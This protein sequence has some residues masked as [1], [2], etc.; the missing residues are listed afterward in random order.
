METYIQELIS[1]QEIPTRD[2][3]LGLYVIAK[4]DAEINQVE[5]AIVA[6]GRQ[7]DL[8]V[9]S[10]EA[11]LSLTELMND[12]DVSHQDA[13]DV[14]WP[15]S[16]RLDSFVDLMARLA[17]KT[18][19][20]GSDVPTGEESAVE[21]EG[22]PVFWLTPVKSQD[23]KT[24]EELVNFLVGQEKLYAFGERT[25]GRKHI[26]EGDRICFYATTNGVVGHAKVAS[27]PNYENSHP[28]IKDSDAYP[29]VFKLAEP[30]LYLHDPVVIDVSLRKQLDAFNKR[31]ETKSWA[32]FVQSTS[33]LSESDFAK[34]TR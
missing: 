14:L 4:Q 2:K 30:K 5:N 25:P 12:N 11:I 10:V 9:S 28:K 18:K 3:A 23:G 21:V 26:K 15:A 29:W 16:P 17:A 31:D 27:K 1:S 34:L 20:D 13:L 33:R 22:A 19:S 24:P 8:R 32:W 7:K 6:E